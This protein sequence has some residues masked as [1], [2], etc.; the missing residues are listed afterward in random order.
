MLEIDKNRF[1]YIVPLRNIELLGIV[2]SR[3][4][5]LGFTKN[6]I[7]NEDPRKFGQ[8][9]DYVA[10]VWMPDE[11]TELII[12]RINKVQ[13]LPPQR[14]GDGEFHIIQHDKLITIELF[15]KEFE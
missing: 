6:Q 7:V 3:L 13:D 1:A 11:P 10:Q 2:E 5:E 9:G 14:A 8:V 4:I 15:D 12:G